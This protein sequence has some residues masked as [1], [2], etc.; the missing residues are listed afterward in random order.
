MSSAISFVGNVSSTA[1]Q[2]GSVAKTIANI[3]GFNQASWR[4][5]PFAVQSLGIKPGRR[6]AVHVYP[7]RDPQWVEDLG[8]G[9]RSFSISGYL[10][11]NDLVTG[12]GALQ[13]QRA[14]MVAACEQPGPGILVHP[15]LGSQ[16]VSL[17]GGCRMTERMDLGLVI[18]VNF[19]FLQ[20]TTGPVFTATNS[21]SAG[22]ASWDDQVT[23]TAAS[24]DSSSASDFASDI[25][26]A[27]QLG[28][29]VVSQGVATVTIFASQASALVGGA[30]MVF[31]ETVG[32]A[33]S[34]GRYAG[35][36]AR[37]LQPASATA[38]TVIA[39][40]TASR[41]A[42]AVAGASA[43]SLAALV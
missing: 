24:T 28:A 25:V 39:A 13:A 36:N 10:I 27:A 30:R 17:I 20:T 3:L 15:A 32:L 18:E 31:S 9:P 16:T 4:G 8:R 5:V 34:L 33:G 12:A 42:V 6:T 1:N 38:A 41:A 23:S 37:T 19:E 35:G 40:A 7:F 43:A 21:S 22:G 26:G 14:A 29:E 11:Q 2:I